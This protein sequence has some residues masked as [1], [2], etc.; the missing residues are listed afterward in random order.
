MTTTTTAICQECIRPIGETIPNDP[1]P[2]CGCELPPHR[3]VSNPSGNKSC[4]LC[5]RGGT[6]K[7][8]RAGREPVLDGV[9]PTIY[10]D[11]LNDQARAEVEGCP[12][13]RPGRRGMSVLCV[14]EAGH[15]GL[16]D[17]GLR[18]WGNRG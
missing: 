15:D 6:A 1:R 7:I 5:A 13:R 17:D 12:E 14:L 16:H 18:Q 8:H 11:E 2:V 9:K 4:A 10:V 3:Y